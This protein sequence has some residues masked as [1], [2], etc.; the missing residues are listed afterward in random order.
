MW[1]RTATHQ[2]RYFQ[3]ASAR[4]NFL[5]NCPYEQSILPQCHTLKSLFFRGTS[6]YCICVINQ[7]VRVCLNLHFVLLVQL[8]I[9]IL[10][11]PCLSRHRNKSSYSAKKF[12]PLQ[13]SRVS[14]YSSSFEIHMHFEVACHGLSKSQLGFCLIYILY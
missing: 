4:D 13:S 3:I 8:P 2:T 12:P 5:F 11:L 6:L 14:C 7:Y 1:V 9:F 10:T